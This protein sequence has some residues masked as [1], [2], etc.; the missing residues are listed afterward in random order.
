MGGQ[1]WSAGGLLRAHGGRGFPRARERT[2]QHHPRCFNPPLRGWVILN[3]GLRHFSQ[4][5]AG[6]KNDPRPQSPGHTTTAFL[7][8]LR[9]E[10]EHMAR[11]AGRAAGSLAG[12]FLVQTWAEHGA[13]SAGGGSLPGPWAPLSG[14]RASR[15]EGT[16]QTC[17]LEGRELCFP[18]S[19]LPPPERPGAWM[20]RGPGDRA[21]QR[22]LQG[23]VEAESGTESD[24]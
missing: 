23:R 18:G 14:G 3:A 11:K 17:S 12:P 8:P 1:T 13:K 2:P 24:P 4:F 16:L 6:G 10:L 20:L 9:P 22:H 5:Q 7:Q 21:V 15:A 19:A